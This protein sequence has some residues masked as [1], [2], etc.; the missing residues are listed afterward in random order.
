M[1]ILITGGAGYIGSHLT[2][3]LMNCN[4][5]VTILDNFNNSLRPTLWGEKVISLDISSPHEMDYGFDVEFDAVI[6]LAAEKQACS[7]DIYD[8]ILNTIHVYRYCV[9][10]NIKLMINTSSAAVYGEG[11]TS[12]YEE[13][14]MVPTSIFH[15]KIPIDNYG[16]SKLGAE[17][18]LN[19]ACDS[20]NITNVINLRLFNVAGKSVVPSMNKMWV[21][22]QNGENVY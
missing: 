1:N 2:H 22:C 21:L 15:N 20:N 19:T 9:S 13:S 16:W 10:H 12:I 3:H 6:H 18:I 17:S 4:H 7:H 11:V 8:N 5:S 14:G